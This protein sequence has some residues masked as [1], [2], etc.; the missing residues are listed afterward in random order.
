MYD[1]TLVRR[2]HKKEIIL[3]GIIKTTLVRLNQFEAILVLFGWDWNI[4]FGMTIKFVL[5]YYVDSHSL[6]A[7]SD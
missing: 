6:R 2:Q 3:G 5:Q 4:M 7:L 1:S